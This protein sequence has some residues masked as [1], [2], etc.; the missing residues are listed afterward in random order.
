MDDFRFQRDLAAAPIAAAATTDESLAQENV[1][2]DVAA[3]IEYSIDGA[4]SKATPEG[5][6]ATALAEA[7]EM[8]SQQI[9]GDTPLVP[10]RAPLHR[11]IASS[12][13]QHHGVLLALCVLLLWGAMTLQ[14]PGA[15]GDLRP[16]ERASHDI[17]APRATTVPDRE[18][19]QERRDEAAALV[20]PEY[21]SGLRAQGQALSNL[22]V[23][24]RAVRQS[25]AQIQAAASPVAQPSRAPQNSASSAMRDGA[26]RDGAMRDGAMRDGAMREHESSS[27]SSTR[28]PARTVAAFGAS[29]QNTPL[30][31]VRHFNG[32]LRAR[33][34]PA[35]SPN[36]AGNVFSVTISR[37][38]AIERAARDGVRA[39]YFSGG[40]VQQIRS[41]VDDDLSLAA[42]RIQLQLDGAAT[43][44]SLAS[45]TRSS[46]RKSAVALSPDEKAVA[47]SLAK[48]AARVP[49]L[50][51]NE[52]KTE[53]AREEARGDVPA[54]GRS[55]LP[56]SVLVEAGQVIDR[57]HWAQLQD[58]DLVA[59]RLDVA[60]A[61]A[62]LLLCAILVGFAAVYIGR[63]SP[64]DLRS[65][66]ALWLLALTPPLTIVLAR[67]LL[68]VPFGETLLA[69]LIAV[70]AMALTI[71]LNARAGILCGLA[72]SLLCAV[73]ARQESTAFAATTLGA[74]IGVLAVSGIVMRAH[75]VRATLLLGL[76]SAMLACVVGA[77][78]E[79]PWSELGSIAIFAGGSGAISVWLAA[80]IAMF[81]ERPLG[82]T[83]HLSLLELSSPDEPVMRRM[84]SEAPGTYTHSL[85]VGQLSEAGAKAVGA[86]PLLC[87]VGGLYH[88]VGKLRRPHCFIENQ[89][90]VNVHD[91][92][93]P[94]LSA[95]LIIAHVK[96]G[97]ELARALH[98][99]RPI[100]D[101]IEQH[102][103][104]DLVSYFHHRA[105]QLTHLSGE[106]STRLVD[107]TT[108]RYPGPRPQ[109]KEAAIVM[110]ADA[111]EAS[112]RALADLTPE[113]LD[114]HIKEMIEKRLHDGELAE[115]ELT[116]RDLSTVQRAFA[117]VLRGALHQ[118]IEY[119]DPSRDLKNEDAAARQTDW[120]R[121][122][123][124]DPQM[125]ASRKR[126]RPLRSRNA[127]PEGREVVAA[128]SFRAANSSAANSSAPQRS[129]MPQ[130]NDG[131]NAAASQHTTPGFSFPSG[132]C[133]KTSQSAN[134][135][136]PQNGNTNGAGINGV[137]TNGA[138]ANGNAT[139]GAATNGAATNGAG[140]S[141]NKAPKTNA[142]NVSLAS[143]AAHFSQART[144]PSPA[145]SVADAAANT[146]VRESSE[147]GEN[148]S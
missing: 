74:A 87:R 13:A 91:R 29:A 71:L 45:S 90:G 72:T 30:E 48:A 39:A 34:L 124:R 142:R 129:D 38:P 54:V 128:S 120:T 147:M 104:K 59:P 1:A 28:T 61:L 126:S 79:T 68:R 137:A 95:L 111:V 75:L 47:F 67:V 123:I 6:E 139:N 65:P 41:D 145:A 76:T 127:R 122:A 108:F 25:A 103:G 106:S 22:N 4:D 69:P 98:L 63:A 121:Q 21:D 36:E 140:T 117:H 81:L 100:H 130:K 53:R 44:S 144:S 102:H 16:G 14:L 101:I 35:L 64:S 136:A 82:I 80:G 23:L 73:L 42:R 114:E 8:L 57:D 56:G 3:P 116:M 131:N 118:R 86:D 11:R 85:M 96:D 49:N 78:R 15:N 66:A 2:P 97:L 60:T 40:R 55:I 88:D 146:A 77:L 94:Q 138:A 119:P 52:R 17:I 26:M 33:G 135:G 37:W 43:P 84:Q 133:G 125:E 132:A 143:F 32:L 93:T 105:V 18:S 50:V 58:L 148:E 51:V 20:T 24:V 109:S 7:S 10:P 5:A 83:T 89:S 12:V 31:T 115:C 110:L 92:L 27:S 141:D 62:R 113:K 46:T 9:L 134:A 19:T 99:P 70:G 112:S 107:E